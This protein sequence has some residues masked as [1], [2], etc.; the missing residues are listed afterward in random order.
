[1]SK[2]RVKQIVTSL[3]VSLLV[4]FFAISAFGQLANKKPSSGQHI[5]VNRAMADDFVI[6]SPSNERFASAFNCPPS[7][8]WDFCEVVIDFPGLLLAKAKDFL[9][10]NTARNVFYVFTCI[11]AP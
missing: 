6:S 9:I 4:C 1:M 3:T 11:N 10:E 2:H 5:Q 7:L 8:D